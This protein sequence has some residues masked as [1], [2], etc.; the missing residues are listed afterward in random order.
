MY[1]FGGI[2]EITKELNDLLVYDFTTKKMS[3]LDKNGDPC[4]IPN[5]TSKMEERVANMSQDGGNSPLG[6]GKTYN[7][8]NR[9][10]GNAS[11]MKRTTMGNGS[12]SLANLNKSPTRK[13]PA[14][15]QTLTASASSA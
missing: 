7:S 11:P 5:F 1:V 12:P 6:R 9:R 3:I 10:G 8:P 15:N 13:A 2:L 4:E 14:G